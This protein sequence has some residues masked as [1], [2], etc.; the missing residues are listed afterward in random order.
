MLFEKQ[1][2]L[3]F[4]QWVYV[5]KELEKVV[6]EDTYFDFISL[7]YKSN[8]AYYELKKLIEKQIDKAEFQKWKILSDLNNAKSRTGNYYLSIIKFYN[9]YCKG[10]NFMQNLAFGY[11]LPL[12][13]PNTKNGDKSYDELSKS[14]REKIVDGFYPEIIEEIDKVL[15]WINS[16]KI[17]LKENSE[18]FN[19]LEYDDLR[20][21][22]DIKTNT[23]LISKKKKDKK[24]WWK[25]W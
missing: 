14:E 18:E 23:Y 25:F 4:E 8:G 7:N 19:Y 11:G 21:Y 24:K 3:E 12:D 17:I 6:D 1:S 20:T 10:Y 16:G 9:L 13:Y 5:S 2:V 22:E 15:Y